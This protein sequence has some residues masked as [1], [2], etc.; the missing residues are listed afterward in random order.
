MLLGMAHEAAEEEKLSLVLMFCEYQTTLE[1]QNWAI[2]KYL[3]MYL[4]AE[5]Y[6]ASSRSHLL[7]ACDKEKNQLGKTRM[8]LQW[9]QLLYF[10]KEDLTRC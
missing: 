8:F 6:M 10:W 7:V 3:S 4:E 9:P 5:G 2:R 1:M